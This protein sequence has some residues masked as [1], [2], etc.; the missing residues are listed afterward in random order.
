MAHIITS[1]PDE[2]DT[3]HCQ[4]NVPKL[5][6]RA[7]LQREHMTFKNLMNREATAT[8]VN[9][10]PVQPLPLAA[11]ENCMS[12]THCSLSSKLRSDAESHGITSDWQNLNCLESYLRRN[13]GNFDF[14]LQATAD[15]SQARRGLGWSL[16]EPVTESV[17]GILICTC[18]NN[19]RI[20]CVTS[21]GAVIQIKFLKCLGCKYLII[22][23]VA[24]SK[25][26]RWKGTGRY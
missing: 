1:R 4:G 23:R 17:T 13:L 5:C 22:V 15:R 19:L 10:S 14:S 6:S 3:G 16:C 18:F 20:W 7:G 2:T 9:S 8:G 24:W 11:L 26:E 25:G 21:L 12:Y